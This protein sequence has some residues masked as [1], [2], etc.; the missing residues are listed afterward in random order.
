M[1][2]TTAYVLFNHELDWEVCV[3]AH[4]HEAVSLG[5]CGSWYI[6]G[7][8]SSLKEL[9]KL[10]EEHD[11]DAEYFYEYVDHCMPHWLYNALNH[12]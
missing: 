11:F 12:D 6:G 3:T 5:G 9:F 2:K 4:K 7:E 1:S 10:F 8:V